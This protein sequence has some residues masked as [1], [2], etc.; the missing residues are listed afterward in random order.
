MEHDGR[1]RPPRTTEVGLVDR[2]IGAIHVRMVE[3]VDGVTFVAGTTVGSD[4]PFADTV[5][6]ALFEPS[7][8]PHAEDVVDGAANKTLLVELTALTG[9]IR[10]IILSKWLFDTQK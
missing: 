1:K 10:V 9:I 2:A 4:E 8:G 7:I 6:I 5:E 3:D